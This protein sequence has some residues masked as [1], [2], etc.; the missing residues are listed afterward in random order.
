MKVAI[1]TS[2][3]QWFIPYAKKLQKKFSGCR[4]FFDHKDINEKIEILFILSYH[5][6][7]P[8]KYLKKSK[9][10]IIIHA[11]DLPK[12]K[13]WAPMFWQ[14][15]EGKNRIVFTM[16]EAG[17][18]VDDGDIYFKKELI[19]NG[20][21]LNAQL[22][23]KQAEHTIKMCEEFVENYEKYKIPTKQGGMESFYPKRGPD[24]S[25]LD[26]NKSIAEQ[27]NLLRIV[28]NEEYPA[29]FYKGNKKYILKIE[30]AKE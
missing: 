24:D 30:E 26:I 8:K 7:I 11:S 23:K 16:F 4:L 17:E 14:I 12:G 9:H 3:N 22:R 1:L 13:G 29:F 25:E 5:Y 2:K 19:L 27:F 21:E 20:Y 18:G 10:N 28:D 15:L 6:I